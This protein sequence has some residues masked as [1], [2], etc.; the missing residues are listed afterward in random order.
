MWALLA[1][2]GK[3]AQFSWA[4]SSQAASSKVEFVSCPVKWEAK[5]CEA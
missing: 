5:Y 3:K 1:Q 4:A 2:Q